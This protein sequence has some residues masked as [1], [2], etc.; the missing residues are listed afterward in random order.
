LPMVP[1]SPLMQG[2]LS[3][4]GMLLGWRAV[5]RFAFVTQIYG[6]REGLRAIPRTIV[7]NIVAMMAARKAVS[8]YLRMRRDGVVRWDKTTHAFPLVIPAE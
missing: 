6:W 2:C 5:M 8:V 3:I 4:G 1:D 7:S